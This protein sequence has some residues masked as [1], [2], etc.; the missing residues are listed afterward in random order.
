MAASRETKR[1]PQCQHEGYSYDPVC[2]L[3]CCGRCCATETGEEMDRRAAAQSRP[4]EG[5]AGAPGVRRLGQDALP[6]DRLP[7]RARYA[8]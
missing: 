2:R 4:L 7:I 6:A 5:A 8:S 3:W 1:C